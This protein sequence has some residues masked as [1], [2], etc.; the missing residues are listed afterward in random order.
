M[1]SR[2][3]GAGKVRPCLILQNDSL[4]RTGHP[5]TSVLPLTSQLTDDAAPLRFKIPA[6]DLLRR[7]SDVMI[8]QIRTIENH[9]LQA[10]ALT[11]LTAEEM[12][13]IGEYLKMVLGLL[14]DV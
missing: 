1:L 7:D 9:R 4:N 3:T 5:S 10:E 2:G 14:E 11:H 8:D 12:A 6:R 13:V